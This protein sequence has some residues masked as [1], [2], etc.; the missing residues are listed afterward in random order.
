MTLML[1]TCEPIPLIIK[2]V[3]QYSVQTPNT[4]LNRNS[5]NIFGN[6][7]DLDWQKHTPPLHLYSIL[8]IA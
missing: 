2:Y 4:K 7:T 8:N 3:L 1:G 6:E 5:L